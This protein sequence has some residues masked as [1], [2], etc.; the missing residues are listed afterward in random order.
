MHNAHTRAT[1]K[2]SRCNVD[3]IILDHIFCSHTFYGAES[4]QYDDMICTLYFHQGNV[5]SKMTLYISLHSTQHHYRTQH[6]IRIL[7]KI[8]IYFFS[9]HII[10]IHVF[11][12]LLFTRTEIK[13]K[14]T[15]FFFLFSFACWLRCLQTNTTYTLTQYT[16]SSN[17]Y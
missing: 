7:F 6:Q 13:K 9:I 16:L 15:N 10:F 2:S 1:N 5:E 17:C 11:S 3:A 8:C 14:T 4:F 12:S